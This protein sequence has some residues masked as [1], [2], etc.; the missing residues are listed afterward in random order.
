ML[1]AFDNFLITCTEGHIKKMLDLEV[2]DSVTELGFPEEDVYNVLRTSRLILEHAAGLEYYNSLESLTHLLACTSTRIVYETLRVLHAVYNRQSFLD[3]AKD[4]PNNMLHFIY[5]LASPS[6]GP[7]LLEEIK[8]TV[9]T[10]SVDNMHLKFLVD[11]QP[12]EMVLENPS[13]E[14]RK[15]QD[16]LVIQVEKRGVLPSDDFAA[17]RHLCKIHGPI[18]GRKQRFGLLTAIRSSAL[19]TASKEELDQQARIRLLSLSVGALYSQ[20]LETGDNTHAEFRKAGANHVLEYILNGNDISNETLL[21]ALD[22]LI[23][24]FYGLDRAR[25]RPEYG[26]RFLQGGPSSVCA[27]YLASQVAKLE[28]GS[29]VSSQ[30]VGKLFGLMS[31]LSSS[32]SSAEAALEA[33]LMEHAMK[34]LKDERPEMRS[35][36]EQCTDALYHIL[37]T[38]SSCIQ[39]FKS[40]GGDKVLGDRLA[41][42]LERG[43][44]EANIL[45]YQQRSLIKKLMNCHC[46]ILVG[47]EQEGVDEVASECLYVTLRTLI[48]GV[49]IFGTGLFANAASCLGKILN[50]DPL[51]YDNIAKLQ[52]V[53][54]YI[55]VILSKTL[56]DNSVFHGIPHTLSAICLSKKGMALVKERKVLS[57]LADIIVDPQSVGMLK[58][59]FSL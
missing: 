59:T 18:Y 15:K 49:D 4:P 58:G 26:G 39:R 3:D 32:A 5:G 47:G 42:E 50:Y 2:D 17:L 51:Q 43:I 30:I 8:Q 44:A 40:V 52:I 36:V 56:R 20:L 23:V 27:R 55:D 46:L 11:R 28:S 16:P 14:R 31:M 25:I 21:V 6:S 54:A 45:D 1:D 9:D 57:V 35:L 33:G 7:T 29:K 53:E 34:I 38:A 37:N 10:N 48:S 19:V 13:A 24:R 12:P 22:A 41:I